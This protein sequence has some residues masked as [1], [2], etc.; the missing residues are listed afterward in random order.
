MVYDNV[1]M[2]NPSIN[3][4]LNDNIFKLSVENKKFYIPLWHHELHFSPQQYLIVKME[5]EI[6]DNYWIMIG[7]I[8]INKKMCIYTIIQNGF[9]KVSVENI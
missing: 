7:I 5:P 2:L 3:D 4:L 6:S 1:I 9:H 8:Y